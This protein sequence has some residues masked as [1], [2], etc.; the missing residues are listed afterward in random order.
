[1]NKNNRIWGW[2]GTIFMLLCSHVVCTAVRAE[3]AISVLM[4]HDSAPYQ[5]VLDGFQ[6]Y[7]RDKGVQA[8][9]EVMHIK[10]GND[11]QLAG[12][13]NQQ[14]VAL[15]YCLGG[16][17]CQFAQQLTP[18]RPI[19]ASMVL[20]ADS[21]L[22]DAQSTGVFLTYSPETQLQWLKKL[23]PHIKRVGV[24][25]NPEENQAQI[26]AA[27]GSARQLGLELVAEPIDTPK[28]LPGALQNLLRKIDILWA[29]PDRTVLAPQTAKEVLLTSFRSRIPVIGAS[30][31][32]VKGGA[33][34]A[35]DPDYPDIGAQNAAMALK[36]IQGT[37][38]NKIPAA[39]PRSVAY[40]LNLKTVKHMKLQVSDEIS[41][42]A[43][44][45][46]Q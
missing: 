5:A 8:D 43:E 46:Y 19:V 22:T 37:P 33:L 21:I 20:T 24:I 9:Y 32:W 3:P 36:L 42:G 6:G 11:K 44:H 40:T 29:L 2:L 28:E 38:I 12:Q 39:E 23:F 30:T 16:Q 13:I 17:A 25:Y 18:R 45:V 7:L 1:M 41:R 10:E 14:D 34:Y 15:I 27:I 26:D 4:S 31:P 35:L